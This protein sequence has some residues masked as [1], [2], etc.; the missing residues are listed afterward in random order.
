MFY[1]L[2]EYLYAPHTIFSFL[3]LFR[4]LTF[5]IIY[6]MVTAFLISLI[7]GRPVIRWLKE[8]NIKDTTRELALVNASNKDG[9]PTMGGILIVI[10]TLIPSILWCNLANRFVQIIIIA[11]IWFALLGYYDDLLK[12]KKNKEGLSIPK[13]L[14]LQFV[15]S[16]ALGVL[17]V[18][19]YSPLPATTAT[20]I[21]IPFYKYP[22]ADLYWFYILFVVFVV[23]ATSN[24]VNFA[25][26]LDGLAIGPAILVT[27]VFGV[28]CYVMGNMKLSDYFQ[29]N[30]IKGVGELSIF[31]AAVIGAGI[32]F[33]WY[34]AY[35]AQLFMG[36]V[37]SM[38]LGGIIAV[39]AIMVK[40][41]ALIVLAG[42]I[43]F[44][45]ALSVFLQMISIN[46]IGRRLFFMAPLHHTFQKRGIAEPKVVVRF[47]IIA[48]IFA[49]IALS[50][51]K[52]R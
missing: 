14:M 19:D 47:W 35:P 2:Y 22:V 43:F 11:T 8:K 34:N 39:I 5:R 46:Y 26:G 18:S 33:L 40:Q 13:K 7:F 1:F 6:A 20:L 23:I 51:L 12:I 9:T 36:D 16:F 15:F 25:D 27:L 17:L 41:E 48:A 29:F 3:R 21:S 4:Y 10:S 24:A 45:E 49:L 38:T 37:G 52:I 31:C 32:G 28:F 30:Y 50:T 44:I 42:M